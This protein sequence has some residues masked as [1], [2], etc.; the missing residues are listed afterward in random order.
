[1]EQ[2]YTSIEISNSKYIGIVFSKNNN[3]KIYQTKEYASQIQAVQDLNIFLK[4][5]VEPKSSLPPGTTHTIF[6]AVKTQRS[7]GTT[8]RCCGR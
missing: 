6:N 4:T 1:M 5:K 7:S 8:G 2:Y 3:E